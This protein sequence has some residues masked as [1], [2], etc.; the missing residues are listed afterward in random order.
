MASMIQASK[1]QTEIT[2]KTT[3]AEY[4]VISQAARDLLPMRDLLQ[5]FSKV[6]KLIVG[7]TLA[8]STIFEDNK[9]CVDLASAHKSCPRTNRIG[10]KY[11]HF[12]AH[13]ANGSIKIKWIYLK[14]QPADIFTK[15]LPVS[16]FEFLRFQ[17]LGW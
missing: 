6:T 8:H 5:E 12:H 4:I 3:E 1:H 2:L 17:L 11:H 14:N 7:N 10:L 16:I 13:V 15:L 9:G